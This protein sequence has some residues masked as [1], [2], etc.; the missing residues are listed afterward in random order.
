VEITVPPVHGRIVDTAGLGTY[1]YQPNSN[2]SGTDQME[3]E[4][5]N[6]RCPDACSYT[7]VVFNTGGPGDCFLPNIITPN[8]DNLNDAFIIPETCIAGEGGV[9]VEVTIF[10]QW[11]DQVF[12]AVPYLNDWEGTYN[13]NPLPAGTYFYVVQFSDPLYEPKKGFLILQR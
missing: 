5:C 2:F 3:Y 9:E 4:I 7:T 12:H 6:L 8:G 11:G 13:G 10:N 1:V